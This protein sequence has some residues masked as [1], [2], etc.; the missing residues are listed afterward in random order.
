MVAYVGLSP[1]VATLPE[2]KIE[3]MVGWSAA[4]VCSPLLLAEM[5]GRLSRTRAA[6]GAERLLIFFCYVAP[7]STAAA[8][9]FGRVPAFVSSRWPDAPASAALAAAAGVAGLAV[10]LA[11]FAEQRAF[12]VAGRY[13]SPRASDRLRMAA[14]PMVTPLLVAGILDLLFLSYRF[15]IYYESYTW[16]QVGTLGAFAL[17]ILWLFPKSLFLV[18]R[19][20][21]L[22]D[23]PLRDTFVRTAHE[24]NVCVGDFVVAKTDYTISNAALLG[25]L[26]SRHVLLT[27]RIVGE[28][29]VDELVA[30]VGHEL[31]HARGGHLRIFTIFLLA[32]G[33]WTWNIPESWLEDFGVVATMAGSTAALALILRFGLGPV[34][35]TCEHEADLYGAAAAGGPDAIVNSLERITGPDR[36]HRASWRHPSVADRVAFIRQAH[37]DPAVA[38]RPRRRLRW[39]EAICALMLL[40]GSAVAVVRQMESL[41]RERATAAIRSSDFTK[42]LAIVREHP[43]EGMARLEKLAL[44]GARTGGAGADALRNRARAAFLRGNTAEAATFARLAGMR[45]GKAT[46]VLFA[47]V[48]E[49]IE[50]GNPMAVNDAVAGP[51]SFVAR[52]PLLGPALRR[53][54]ESIDTKPASRSGKNEPGKRQ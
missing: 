6:A 39:I 1:W 2:P 19:S 29:P 12:D 43:G 35:R 17:A 48:L 22:A 45:S 38:S 42:A 27:D 8:L 18:V 46:D 51:A 40:A 11:V 47:D 49:A 5:A 13:E 54:L 41:P 7:L 30:I 10:L 34:A 44:A 52:D 14:L 20:R 32:V 4:A 33:V 37:A 36:W 53:K 3:E 28:H 9:A 16:A 15:R 21:P 26:G 23:G 31:G 50:D 24:M 25:G